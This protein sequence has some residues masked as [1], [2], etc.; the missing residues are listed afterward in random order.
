MNKNILITGG[1]GYIGSH[2][3]T[4]LIKNG[5]Q[6]FLLDNLSNSSIETFHNLEKLNNTKIPL[7]ITDIR[8]SEE[9]KVIIK[10]N[11]INNIMHL[12]ALKSVEE[13][14]IKKNEYH[15]NNVNGL[16]SLLNA[17]EFSNRVNFIFSGSACIYDPSLRAPFSESDKLKP[18]NPY[19]QTKYQCEEI[20]KEFSN[21]NFN[22]GIL[23]YFNPA[24][25]HKSSLIGQNE[26]SNYKNLFSVID[27]VATN[28]KLVL[29]I[30]GSD[31]NTRDG[32][33]VRDYF[34]VEDLADGHVKAIEY[35]DN[36]NKSIILNLGSG[37]GYSVLDIVNKYSMFNSIKIPYKLMPRRK[38]DMA[39]VYA[40]IKMAK[41]I[42]N[43]EPKMSLEQIC[44][45]SYKWKLN[46]NERAR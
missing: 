8:K 40:S 9:I 19:G 42:I 4:S 37:I 34:H 10:N 32:T 45:S 2:L 22:Y 39:M 41:K 15:D 38:G 12:A 18:S 7:F 1:L 46:L 31:Y 20:L 16:L 14:L 27:S 23:R 30:F 25:A 6:P 5:Y 36:N 13:S 24:G 28:E 33:C 44:T 21:D 35:L 43:W 11:N 17:I 3:C 29:D 26:K